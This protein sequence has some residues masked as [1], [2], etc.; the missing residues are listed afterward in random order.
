MRPWFAQQAEQQTSGAAV[1]ITD[2]MQLQVTIPN[3]T[4]VLGGKTLQDYVAQGAAR[5][6]SILPDNFRLPTAL[7]FTAG[8]GW[9]INSNSS[10]NVDLRAR[11]H[12]P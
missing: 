7:N 10:L 5:F 12:V 2:R 8:F 6:A 9:Q 1:R 3:L 11:P 4:A